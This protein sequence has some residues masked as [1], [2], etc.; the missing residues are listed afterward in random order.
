M[1]Q[2]STRINKRAKRL[3]VTVYP[4]GRVVVTMPR[5]ISEDV[6]QK[7]VRSKSAWILETQEKMRKKQERH[8]K[9]PLGLSLITSKH[10]KEEIARYSAEAR[11]LAAARLAHFIEEYRREHGIS[12][13]YGRISI[14][15]Q[16]TRWGSCSRRKDFSFNY[17]LACIPAELADYVIVHELCHTKEMNHSP[18][19]WKLVEKAVPDYMARRKALR[20]R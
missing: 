10:T 3:L 12:L 16:K 15:N 5:K 8:A 9:D 20:G 17:R 18:K 11:A 13:S 6:L 19:F 7:F 1:I 14:R 4:D 2:Y